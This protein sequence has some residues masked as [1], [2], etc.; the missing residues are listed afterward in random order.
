MYYL[1]GANGEPRHMV[2]DDVGFIPLIALAATSLLQ[3]KQQSQAK[4]LEKARIRAASQ[5]AALPQGSMSQGGMFGFSPL[6][7]GLLVGV[8]VLAFMFLR[9]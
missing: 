9:K 4:K 7:I 2:G 5:Q 8:P 6:T 1:Q 3:L